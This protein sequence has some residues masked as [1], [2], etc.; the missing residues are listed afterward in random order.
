[1]RL[2]HSCLPEDPALTGRFHTKCFSDRGWADPPASQSEGAGTH[3]VTP[4]QPRRLI[5]TGGLGVRSHW[6][7]SVSM[8]PRFL[9]NK[10]VCFQHCAEMLALGETH[11][12]PPSHG[13]T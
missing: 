13:D 6:F 5:R 9:Q 2:P 7:S 4:P 8:A 3:V 11:H 1:M 12:P 10:T